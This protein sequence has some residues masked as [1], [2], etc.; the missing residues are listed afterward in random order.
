L[1]LKKQREVWSA[2]L[3]AKAI[4]REFCALESLHLGDSASRRRV[5]ACTKSINQIDKAISILE[6]PAPAPLREQK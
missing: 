2:L 3:E 4:V 1:N 5:R 6:V